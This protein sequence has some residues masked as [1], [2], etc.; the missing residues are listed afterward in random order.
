MRINGKCACGNVTFRVDGEPVAQF[1]CHCR[2]CQ[3]A[4]AA[5]VSAIAM[6]PESS[7]AYSGDVRSVKVTGRDGAATRVICANCGTKVINEPGMQIRAILP[8]LCESRDWF[9]PT[10]HIQWQDHTLEMRD[11][12]PKF[13]DY[14]KEFGGTGN[15]V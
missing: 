9:K 14:P 3:T 10:M 8:A 6:F 7:V 1:Y 4:H 5:P 15:L 13:V 11:D 2:S 12:L